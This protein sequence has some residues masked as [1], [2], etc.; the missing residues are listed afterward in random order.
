VRGAGR[1]VA[2]AVGDTS[3]RVDGKQPFVACDPESLRPR[4][5]TA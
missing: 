1:A 2:R 3:S 5:G 4:E